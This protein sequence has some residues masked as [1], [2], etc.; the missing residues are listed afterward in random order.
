[1]KIKP[2]YLLRTVAGQHVV[3]PI[4]E[5]AVNFNGIIT[6]NTSGKTLWEQLVIGATP[7]QL[8]ACLLERYQVS[9]EEAQIDVEAFLTKVRVHRL[10]VDHE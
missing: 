9:K 2:G 7:D 10:L 4:G 1:M 8:V 3:V 5:Q 6:L